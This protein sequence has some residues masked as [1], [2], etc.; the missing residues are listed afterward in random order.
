MSEKASGIERYPHFNDPTFLQPENS[1]TWEVGQLPGGRSASQ[2]A[3]LRANQCPTNCDQFAFAENVLDVET[4]VRKGSTDGCDVTLNGLKAAEIPEGIVKLNLGSENCVRDRHI[5]ESL[6]VR[7]DRSLVL[8]DCQSGTPLHW[9]Q[10][11]GC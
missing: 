4:N 5:G 2:F 6:E 7:S 10:L 3:S 1:V 9:P 11:G 8:M